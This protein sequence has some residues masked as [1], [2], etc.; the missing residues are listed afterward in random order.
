MDARAATLTIRFLRDIADRTHHL[1]E[2]RILFPAIDARTIFPGCG[3]LH[4][5]EPGRDRV[6]GMAEAVAR[7]SQGDE[8]A[9]R[10]AMGE[11]VFERFAAVAEEIEASCRHRGEPSSTGPSS[12]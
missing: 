9:E 6:R 12:V 10:Q 2:E 8:E 4:E 7:A 1:K 5:H 11:R 3:L